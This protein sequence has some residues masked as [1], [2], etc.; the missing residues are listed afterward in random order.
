MRKEGPSVGAENSHANLVP[1]TGATPE[2]SSC[3]PLKRLE[4]LEEGGSAGRYIRRLVCRTLV[5]SQDQAARSAQLANLAGHSI[6]KESACALDLVQSETGI[7]SYC[8]ICCKG[9]KPIFSRLRHDQ[10]VFKFQGVATDYTYGSSTQCVA[11]FLGLVSVH[12]HKFT[13]F[14]KVKE[15]GSLS[16]VM[17]F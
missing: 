1:V 6:E 15:T 9:C 2:V 4:Q 17:L 7:M 12:P 11:M 14:P 10:T 16:L 13:V 5:W 8:H 3:G